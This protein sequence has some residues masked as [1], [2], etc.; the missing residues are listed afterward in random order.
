[1]QRLKV[2]TDQNLDQELKVEIWK[3]FQ[4]KKKQLT[5]VREINKKL[6]PIR[7]IDES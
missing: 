4:E 6:R 1:M 7:V 5:L 3:S 2:E